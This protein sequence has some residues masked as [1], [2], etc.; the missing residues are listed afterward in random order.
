MQPHPRFGEERADLRIYET[1]LEE[2]TA[3]IDMDEEPAYE[4]RARR[5]EPNFFQRFLAEVTWPRVIKWTVISGVVVGVCVAIY[6]LHASLKSSIEA[7]K[8]TVE[9][10]NTRNITKLMEIIKTQNRTIRLEHTVF[11]SRMKWLSDGLMQDEIKEIGEL[12][13]QNTT[14]FEQLSRTMKLDT[15]PKATPNIVHRIISRSGR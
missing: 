2:W 10:D 7:L 12:I 4:N 5:P 6:K 8:T 11:N 3:I 14:A 9:T 13:K 1:R 15:V